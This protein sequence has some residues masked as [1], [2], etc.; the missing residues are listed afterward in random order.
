MEVLQGILRR[1]W[2]FVGE[3]AQDVWHNLEETLRPI[4]YRKPLTVYEMTLEALK[5]SNT[6]A[7]I[8]RGDSSWI[9][10]EIVAADVMETDVLSLD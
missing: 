8:I 10:S 9:A 3:L 6:F 1:G 2:V 7:F 5:R 4:R